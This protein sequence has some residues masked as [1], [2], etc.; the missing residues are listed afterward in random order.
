MPKQ[1]VAPIHYLS[2]SAEINQITTEQL[3]AAVS[4]LASQGTQEIHLL[5]STTGGI[6]NCGISIYNTL[7]ALPCK[8]VTYNVANVDSIGIVVFL[9]GEERFACQSATFGF[10]G[11]SQI[12]PGGQ[13]I[14]LD[15]KL[16]SDWRES[17]SVN[18]LRIG[19]IYAKHITL[20]A[21]GIGQLFVEATTKQA[22]WAESVSLI[23]A[24]REPEVPPGVPI[25]S[26]VFP[27]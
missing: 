12:V 25:G 2:F 19:Q 4:N 13:P 10:H 20:D 22:G 26:F 9:A 16:L 24:I 6:V 15:A 8:I 7:R 5:L 3:L 27:R 21:E 17:V 18:N 23:H 14:S 11:V 1:K